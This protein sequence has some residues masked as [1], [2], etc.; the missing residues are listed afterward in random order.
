MGFGGTIFLFFSARTCEAFL[1]IA[2]G[3]GRSG[4]L[5]GEVEEVILL[6]SGLV[7]DEEPSWDWREGFLGATGGGVAF[8]PV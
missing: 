5:E 3:F 1:G 6:C 2:G 8:L 7:L 4:I